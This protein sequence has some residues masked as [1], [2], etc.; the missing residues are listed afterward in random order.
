MAVGQWRVVWHSG[1]PLVGVMFKD[2]GPIDF[3]TGT[4]LLLIPLFALRSS[5][6][7]TLC[8]QV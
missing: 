6:V 7:R 3:G 2:D 1:L 5:R 4:M 8:S